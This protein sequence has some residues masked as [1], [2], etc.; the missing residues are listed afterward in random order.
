M[1]GKELHFVLGHSN[2]KGK[3]REIGNG[4][5][6]DERKKSRTIGKKKKWMEGE[7][8]NGLGPGLI[9]F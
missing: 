3:R 6:E 8:E 1:K 9:F 5:G 2:C 4:D 7:K